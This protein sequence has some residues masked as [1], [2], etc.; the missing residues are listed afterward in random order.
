MTPNSP[1]LGR[2]K[3]KSCIKCKTSCGCDVHIYN[4]QESYQEMWRNR[5]SRHLQGIYTIG[6]HEGNGGTGPQQTHKIK[7]KGAL[8]SLNIIY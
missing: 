4:S 2:R 5:R 3:T 1:A 6:I 8:Q 7:K